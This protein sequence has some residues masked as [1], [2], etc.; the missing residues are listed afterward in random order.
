MKQLI[1]TAALSLVASIATIVAAENHPTPSLRGPAALELV[2]RESNYFP[3]IEMVDNEE[4]KRSAAD[5]RQ[6][7]RDSKRRVNNPNR[8]AR[9]DADEGRR[10]RTQSERSGRGKPKIDQ[11]GGA[12]RDGAR[13]TSRKRFEGNDRRGDRARDVRS[14]SGSSRSSDNGRRRS[15]SDNRA[16]DNG[17]RRSSD[18]SDNGRRHR[19]NNYSSTSRSNKRCR[20]INKNLKRSGA[21]PSGCKIDEYGKRTIQQATRRHRNDDRRGNTYSSS[22][23]GSEDENKA[24]HSA[25]KVAVA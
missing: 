18:N 3:N 25:D 9:E 14:G 22:T 17:R 10:K 21:N 5:E 1:I 4:G 2:E 8:T 20:D 13:S 24:H 7:Q 16:S 23:W 15:S 6:G 12:R 11:E 19:G